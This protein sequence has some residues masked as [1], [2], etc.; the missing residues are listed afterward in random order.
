MLCLHFEGIKIAIAECY[1]ALQSKD[2][3]RHYL[4][5]PKKI[6]NLPF[7]TLISICEN[8]AAYADILFGTYAERPSVVCVNRLL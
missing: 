3:A 5:V 6:H 4:L 7:L 2:K 1:I 8:T